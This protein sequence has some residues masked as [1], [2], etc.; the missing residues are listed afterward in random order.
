[1]LK[2]AWTMT[3][4]D[5][6]DTL[7]CEPFHDSRITDLHSLP[8][9]IVT[10]SRTFSRASCQLHVFALSFNWI[11]RLFASFVLVQSDYFGFDFT[12]FN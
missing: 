6:K 2:M 1:M 12:T 4:Q 5:E 10:R 11:T 9:P 7:L 8:K 3:E